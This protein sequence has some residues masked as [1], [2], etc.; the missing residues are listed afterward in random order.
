MTTPAEFLRAATSVGIV[1][2]VDPDGDSLGSS[3]GLAWILDAAGKR[4]RV[5]LPAKVPRQYAFLPGERFIHVGEEPGPDHEQVAVLDCTSPSRL[6]PLEKIVHAGAPV[7]NIDHHADNTHFGDA[8]RVDPSAAATA[9]L[10]WEIAQGAGLAIPKEAAE[11]LYTGILT[12]TGRFTFANTDERALR[13]SADLIR[14]GAEAGKIANHVYEQRPESA[15]RL[16]GEALETLELREDG[17]VA[18]LHVTQEMLA[19]TGALPEETEGF[20]AYARSIAG[21]Q[22]GIFLRETEDGSVK[23]SFRS[24]GGVPID[25]V[26]N[27]FGGGGHPVAAGARVPGPLQT[28]K[29]RILRAVGEHLQARTG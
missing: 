20:A 29:E 16:L 13:T 7:L 26:A 10:I 15:V 18:C 8:L 4:A 12:D 23:V 9:I 3:L 17:R 11:C 22:V 24:M 27:Q 6:G 28:A 25:G 1:S 2:H 14:A 19:A 5:H 21:V